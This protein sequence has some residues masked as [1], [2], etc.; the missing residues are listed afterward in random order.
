[1]RGATERTRAR[2][3]V[4][5]V[6]AL[7][8]V[9]LMG[10]AA[11]AIDGSRMLEERRHV[12]AAADH[13]ALAAAHHRCTVS[14]SD[15][16]TARAAGRAA[17]TANGF[18]D[19]SENAI[20]TIDPVAE[21]PSGYTYR[22]VI[23]STIAGTFARVL[24]FDTFR[25]TAEATAGGA[26]CAAGAGATGPGA[27][28]AGGICTVSGKYGIDISGSSSRVYGSLHTNDDANV[29][30]SSNVFTEPPTPPEE[31]FTHV[32]SFIGSE[33]N[34]TF[35]APWPEQV[36][37]PTPLWPDGWD[38]SVVTGGTGV[39]TAGSF[40]RPYYDLA[41]AQGHF[42]IGKITNVNEPGVYYSTATD[43]AVDASITAP[44]TTVAVT[45]IAPNGKIVIGASSKSVTPVVDGSLPRP[46]LIMLS[47]AVRAADKTC[48]DPTILMSGSDVDWNGIIWGVS[49]Q[50]ELSGSTNAAAN[51]G[52]VA[53]SVKLNGSSL[54][55]RY[56][57]DLFATSPDPTIQLL[58]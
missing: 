40:L 42:S 29:G 19:A 4:L 50:V 20:V 22:S 35:Q 3:Q 7:G 9:V 33:V 28:Y 41:L 11:L 48:E 39:P 15:S 24:G 23:T 16:A 14:G 13:A 54:L 52:I 5:V 45:L 57:P 10:G 2:G 51:G 8:A 27:V 43:V 38:P 1:M 32:G 56:N 58:K 26:N 18:D 46:G 17:A 49:G 34:N 25:I 30:G 47:K 6:V 37:M 36:P 31:H 12:Q 21:D 44:G 55:I 53:H